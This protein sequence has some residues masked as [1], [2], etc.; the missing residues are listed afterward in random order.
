MK[1]KAI[2]VGPGEPESQNKATEIISWF[3]RIIVKAGKPDDRLP[4]IG[5][6]KYD[7]RW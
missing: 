2:G 1:W 7:Y 4:V 3:M 5:Y 6:N